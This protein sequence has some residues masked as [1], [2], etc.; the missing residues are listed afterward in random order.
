MKK[1]FRSFY[2]FSED[3]F[4]H[5]WDNSIFVFDAN[6]LLNLYRYS[7][8]TRNDLFRVLEGLKQ[9]IWIPNQVGLEYHFN[10]LSV[11]YEQKNSY[12]SIV[13]VLSEQSKQSIDSLN[14]GLNKYKKRHASINIKELIS[15]LE[16]SYISL[17]EKVQ[18]LERDHID[19]SEEDM[20][21]QTLSELFDSKVGDFNT[22]AEL[23]EI[24][25]DG[26]K[27]Y[28]SDIPP[29]YKDLNDK[30][31]KVKYYNN[32]FLQSE[33]GD[34]IVWNQI[35]QKAL[36]DNIN[37]IF[38]TDDEKED[39]WQIIGGK[40]IGPRIELLNEFKTK[41]NKDV[42]LYKPYRFVEYAKE[43]L[44][45]EIRSSSIEEIKEIK[46]T[47]SS[48]EEDSYLTEKDIEIYT[49]MID[50]TNYVDSTSANNIYK[51][52]NEWLERRKVQNKLEKNISFLQSEVQKLINVLPGSKRGYFAAKYNEALSTND[53]FVLM[54]GLQ[55]LYNELIDA[56]D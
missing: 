37:I 12:N 46:N 10:R 36:S 19:Y 25:T 34:L 26:A 51:K 4:K 44:G 53:T 55:L 52:A 40:T 39:W 20:I 29:G 28:K 22:Q 9:K 1:T 48:G 17:I 41:T 31:G 7:E 54:N 43:Y 13:K 14:T 6:V 21:L 18:N 33:Y 24:Y 27:R 23:N 35:I 45:E 50:R 5:L 42:Y 56:L 32:T 3:E 38:V 16:E 30:K 11:I 49:Q 47:N 2:G 8:D 15:D